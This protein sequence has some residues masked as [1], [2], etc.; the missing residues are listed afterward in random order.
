MKQLKGKAYKIG[1]CLGIF[2]IDDLKCVSSY[3]LSCEVNQ[4]TFGCKQISL[5]IWKSSDDML[6]QISPCQSNL[7]NTKFN[8][9]VLHEI[10]GGNTTW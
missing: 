8:E 7:T 3:G 6:V 10:E 4:E 5:T 2:E 1:S 9:S